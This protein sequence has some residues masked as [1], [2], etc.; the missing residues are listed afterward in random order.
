MGLAISNKITS[1]LCED[2][3]P[4]NDRIMTLRLPLKHVR[5]CTIVTILP[6]Q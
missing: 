2:P 5:Y 6:Q 1:K 4:V 3:K